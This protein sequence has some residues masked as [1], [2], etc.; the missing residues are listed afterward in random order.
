LASELK[1]IPILKGEIVR[2]KFFDLHKLQVQGF[3]DNAA[4]ID[5]D[6]FVNKKYT[7]GCP[8]NSPES[9]LCGVQSALKRIMPNQNRSDDAFFG[10]HIRETINQIRTL[11]RR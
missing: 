11:F 10:V 3:L 9:T 2:K 7:L 8:N 5:S 6:S 1:L 4:A